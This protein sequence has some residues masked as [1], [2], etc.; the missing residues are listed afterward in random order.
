MDVSLLSKMV[1]EIILDNDSVTLPGLGSFVA[2]DVPA[3]FSDKGYTIN[4]PYRKLSFT[5]REGND[6]RLADLYAES[7]GVSREA[8]LR[9]LSG[10]LSDLR[11][12]LI[13]KK[14]VVLTGLGRLR[15]TRENNF[16]F[17]PDENPDIDPSGF[18]LYPVSLKTHQETPEEVSAAV[19]GLAAA[20]TAV[21][22]TEPDMTREEE[23]PEEE[24][25]TDE[26][27]VPAKVPFS[28]EA[29]SAGEQQILENVPAPSVWRR[30]AVMTAIALAVFALLLILLAILGRVAPD[31]V[32]RLLYTREELELLKL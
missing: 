31:L 19:S 16:F 20:F 22:E 24:R 29:P 23:R 6:T 9:D 28:E 7:N 15:A 5:Q 32:D 2:E 10:F 18:G 12:T 21:P 25:L 30:L 17:V 1:R 4:P 14:V 13:S 27:P 8:A 11:G 3:F 26:D